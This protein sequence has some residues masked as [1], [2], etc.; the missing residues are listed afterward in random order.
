M[1]MFFSQVFRLFCL[2]LFLYQVACIRTS[3]LSPSLS[4][5]HPPLQT[6]SYPPVRPL[7]PPPPGRGPPQGRFTDRPRS[8]PPDLLKGPPGGCP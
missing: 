5:V 3:L 4:P 2:I 1:G 7:R 8:P 6:S